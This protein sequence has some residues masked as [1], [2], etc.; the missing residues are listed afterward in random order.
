MTPTEA[1]RLIAFV[2]QISPAQKF[3][4]FT[5]D[6]WHALLED[7]PFG[8]SLE[9]VKRIGRRQPYVAPA[10]VI[11]EVRVIRRERLDRA[12]ATFAYDGNPDDVVGYKRAL[13]AHRRAIGDGAEPPAAPELT[14][15]VPPAAISGVFQRP[16]RAETRKAIE[17][18]PK[19]RRG[20]P[21]EESLAYARAE[22]AK[23]A[24]DAAGGGAA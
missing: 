8:D 2:T 11:A 6:A 19:D 24:R 20:G 17:A 4:E 14:V 5:A 15:S 10:D 1:V 21:S 18:A 3:D 13:A 9:A 22:L 23:A 12:D 16:P 7:V